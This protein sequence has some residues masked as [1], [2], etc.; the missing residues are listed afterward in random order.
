MLPRQL[1]AGI[2][3]SLLLSLIT[4]LFLVKEKIL[5]M[6]LL[7]SFWMMILIVCTPLLF[8]ILKMLA[9]AKSL[10]L[11]KSPLLSLAQASPKRQVLMAL[12]GSFTKRIGI[13]LVK[14]SLFLSKLFFG[15]VIFLKILTT[16]AQPSFQKWT[17]HPKSINLNQLAFQISITK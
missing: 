2:T 6:N 9:F 5:E 10:M 16:P 14:L 4:S 12:L 17:I 11:Q 13:L 8:F 7:V 3:W 15:M 1:D